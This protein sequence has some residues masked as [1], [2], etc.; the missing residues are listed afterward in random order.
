SDGHGDGFGYTPVW[1]GAELKHLPLD[2]SLDWL[3]EG[4]GGGPRNDIGRGQTGLFEVFRCGLP[5]S[6]R[7]CW[8]SF[9]LWGGAP[10][11]PP[12][13]RPPPPPPRPPTPPPAPRPR[14]HRGA[15]ARPAP[16]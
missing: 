13:G 8:G 6:P 9:W 15:A 10:P 5:R 3:H 1:P 4:I 7:C 12:Q 11:P 14:R 2:N 16:S